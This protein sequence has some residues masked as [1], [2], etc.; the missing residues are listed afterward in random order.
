[1]LSSTWSQNGQASS[2]SSPLLANLPEVQHL[3]CNASQVK[4]LHLKGALDFHV[5][6]AVGSFSRAQNLAWYADLVEKEPLGSHAHLTESTE[7]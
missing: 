6:C 4:N 7:S 1:M 5:N 3:F 2:W